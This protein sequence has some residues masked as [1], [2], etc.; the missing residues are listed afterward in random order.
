MATLKT[1]L[2]KLEAI[3]SPADRGIVEVEITVVVP[4]GTSTE[5]LV[6]KKLEDGTWTEFEIHQTEQLVI[7]D[8]YRKNM[9]CFK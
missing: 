9:E 7:V 1:R 4:D 8:R 6:S 3:H 2:E 5:K